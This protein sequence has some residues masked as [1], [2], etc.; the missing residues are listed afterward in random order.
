MTKTLKMDNAEIK[1]KRGIEHY[2][3]KE[4]FNRLQ[5]IM[6][7]KQMARGTFLFWEGDIA[8]KLYSFVQDKFT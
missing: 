5:S 4:N 8:N 2:F 7:N 3:G 1:E 6:Y